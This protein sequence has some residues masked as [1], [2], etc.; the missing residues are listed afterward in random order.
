MK[1]K[2]IVLRALTSLMAVCLT[3]LSVG[4][5]S[6]GENFIFEYDQKEIVVSGNIDEQKAQMIAFTLNGEISITPYSILCIFGHSISQGT[7][8]ETTHRQY[9]TA[10]RCLRKTYRV[11]YCTRSSCNHAVYTLTAQSAIFCCT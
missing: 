10:P 5:V 1:T 6:V 7:A 11:D 9:A 4:A 8:T 3:V 2:R